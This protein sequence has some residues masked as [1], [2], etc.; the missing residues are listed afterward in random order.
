MPVSPAVRR[1]LR[2]PANIDSA[3]G[4][5]ACSACGNFMTTSAQQGAIARCES[6][7]T[8]GKVTGTQLSP[9]A[10][11][12]VAS[13]YAFSAFMPEAPRWGYPS[14]RSSVMKSAKCVLVT[15][16]RR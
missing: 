9:I 3:G 7:G 2:L 12:Y 1:R 15:M 6:Y 8:Y 10:E 4:A 14:F 16:L 13:G 11:D 5:V